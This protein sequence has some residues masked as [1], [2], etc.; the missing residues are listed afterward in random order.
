MADL[1]ELILEGSEET[2]KGKYLTFDVGKET[3][4]IP[5]RYVIEIVSM[6]ALTEMPEMP[7]FI[8]GIMNLRGKIIPVMDVRLRFCMQEKE[9]DDRTCIIVVDMNDIS[10]GLVIDSVSDVLTINDDEIMDKPAMSSRD[11]SSYIDKIGRANNQ[12][13]LLINCGELISAG[14]MSEVCGCLDS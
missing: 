7:E 8:K 14:D 13:I 6:Q 2:L 5:I 10:V 4:G 9:Y 11:G 1:N 3:Y 12:V